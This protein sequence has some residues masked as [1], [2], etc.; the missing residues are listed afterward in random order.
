MSSLHSI[1]IGLFLAVITTEGV[2]RGVSVAVAMLL[3]VVIAYRLIRWE[4]YGR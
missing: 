3:S 1:S 2:T 4:V